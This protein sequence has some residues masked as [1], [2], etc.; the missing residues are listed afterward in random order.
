MPATAT[1]SVAEYRASTAANSTTPSTHGTACTTARRS[2]PRS[3]TRRAR[4]RWR[5]RSASVAPGPGGSGIRI[6]DQPT[7]NPTRAPSGA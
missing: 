1:A 7:A 4:R 5:S 2:G 6:H 3:T